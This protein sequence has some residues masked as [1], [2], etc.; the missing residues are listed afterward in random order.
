VRFVAAGLGPSVLPREAVIGQVKAR[1]LVLV[2]LADEWAERQFVIITRGGD[3]ES[4]TTKL[5]VRHLAARAK[6]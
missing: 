3:S 4:A 2:P 1:S 6:L 5:L